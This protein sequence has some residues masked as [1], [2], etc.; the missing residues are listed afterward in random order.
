MMGDG[1][2]KVALN[3]WGASAKN[4][5][6]EFFI[7]KLL[8]HPTGLTHYDGGWR[9]HLAQRPLECFHETCTSENSG[10]FREKSFFYRSTIIED[11]LRSIIEASL[12]KA[13]HYCKLAYSFLAITPLL[14]FTTL[15]VHL[16]GRKSVSRKSSL[17]LGVWGD[18]NG[19][20]KRK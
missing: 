9:F 8:T 17:L 20:S 2:D 5:S 1:G 7:D 15:R 11:P 4:D 19:W 14:Q 3:G 18:E 16:F 10:V 6:T 13:L 12:T